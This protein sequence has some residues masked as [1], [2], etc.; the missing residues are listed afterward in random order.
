MGRA[1]AC[2]Q[3]L[4][5]PGHSSADL[6]S[7]VAEEAG[8][9]AG[10]ATAP[11]VGRALA[12]F[13]SGLLVVG[14][15]AA[16]L[17]AAPAMHAPEVVVPA[18]KVALE[19]SASAANTTNSSG[20]TL[21]C[22]LVTRPSGDEFE[23]VKSQASRRIGIFACSDSAVVSSAKLDLGVAGKSYV[24][25]D[26]Q[27]VVMPWG[28]ANTWVFVKAWDAILVGG[29]WKKHD[30]VVKADPDAVLFPDRLLRFLSQVPRDVLIAHNGSRW[31]RRGLFLQN[32]QVGL[33]MRGSL[34]VISRLGVETYSEH[35]LECQAK[36]NPSGSG[37]DGYMYACWSMLGV[38][39]Y[40][41]PGL[42]QDQYCSAGSTVPPNCQDGWPAAFHPL[43]HAWN[44]NN[45]WQT[46]VACR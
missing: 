38:G 17:A 9:G 27:A 3:D 20:P 44:W 13:A 29:L 8:V 15:L 23:M 10:Q 43:K 36:N 11:G 4:L 28:A 6:E 45:C 1:S 35:T 41:L 30:W 40:T 26:M 24:I 31:G 33:S 7:D 25:D 19:A 46:S 39:K 32:C 16:K 5:F 21:F 34:E 18:E 14:L 12:V 42:I 37:E 22:F 2:Q